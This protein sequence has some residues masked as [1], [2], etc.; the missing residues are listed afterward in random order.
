MLTIMISTFG[1]R[2]LEL[3]K[4][5]QLHHPELSYLIIHQNYEGI[6]IP[7]FLLRNDIRIVSTNTVGLSKSRNIGI[8]NC[9][10]KYALVADDDIEYI[11]QGIESV[12]KIIR[13]EKPDFAAFKILTDKEEPPYKAYT[14]EK[15]S[16]EKISHSISSIEL[17][18][19]ITEIKSKGLFFDQRF[20][21]GTIL[22]KAEEEILVEDMKSQK[23]KGTY[24]PIYIVKH[25]FE[26]TKDKTFR[27]SFR[28]FLKGAVSQRTHKSFI[29][30]EN[31]SAL[32]KIKNTVFYNLGKIY[33]LLTPSK[34]I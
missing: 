11:P 24:Y 14:E 22:K 10:T 34:G 4:T 2:L 31:I 19:N 13:N 6:P 17:L 18:L 30:P 16:I 25:P 3:E 32:R 33:I 27:E 7:S 28:H 26:S 29:L 23:L 5:V 9:K 1:N 15:Q 21:L 20:G 8:K 12:L